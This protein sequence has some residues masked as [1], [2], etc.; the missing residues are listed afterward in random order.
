MLLMEA[1]SSRLSEG[2]VDRLRELVR[3]VRSGARWLTLVRSISIWCILQAIRFRPNFMQK[4]FASWVGHTAI[5]RHFCFLGY[6]DGLVYEGSAHP[7][8]YTLYVLLVCRCSR[9]FLG[10]PPP[11]LCRVLVHLRLFR[12]SSA[13]KRYWPLASSVWV[14]ETHCFPS[15]ISRYTFTLI[16]FLW[17]SSQ[18]QFSVFGSLILY[19]SASF[20]ILLSPAGIIFILDMNSVAI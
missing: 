18:M 3:R 10:D 6:L 11:R 15:S 2:E 14:L 19:L 20:V 8:P 13:T 9:I 17:S 4:G 12:F 5:A 7:I 1:W 16:P